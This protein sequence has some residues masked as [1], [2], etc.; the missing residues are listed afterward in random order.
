M[1]CAQRRMSAKQRPRF[2]GYQGRV[3][4]AARGDCQ[5]SSANHSTSV[6]YVMPTKGGLLAGLRVGE[7][8]QLLEVAEADLDRPS[9]GVG[10]EDLDDAQGRVSTKEDAQ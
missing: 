3:G 7:A 6:V 1:R 5:T 4:G 9:T 10:L 2:C 8:E